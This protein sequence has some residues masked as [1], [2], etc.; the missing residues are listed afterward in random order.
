MRTSHHIFADE[1]GAPRP[2][3]YLTAYPVRR[4]GR[5]G[6]PMGVVTALMFLLLVIGLMV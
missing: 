5:G 1:T 3:V 2:P 4:R 6:W